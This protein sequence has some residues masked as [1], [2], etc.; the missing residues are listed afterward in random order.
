MAGAQPLRMNF[1]I[2]ALIVAVGLVPGLAAAEEGLESSGPQNVLLLNIG[3]LLGGIISVEHEHAVN[4]FL[5][6]SGGLSVLA[7]R[8]AFAPAGQPS[9]VVLSPEVGVRFHFIRDAPGGL[10]VGPSLNFGYIAWSSGGPVERA[11]SY[12]LGAAVGY[13]FILG[14]HFVLQL[15]LGGGFNDYGD[16]PVWSPRFRLGLGGAF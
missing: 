2:V 14:D 11:F 10:W 15:G 3:D 7:F 16:G 9:L 1:R 13:N 12:G 8:G 6:V 5:G 4:S